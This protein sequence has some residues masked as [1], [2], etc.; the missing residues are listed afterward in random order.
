MVTRVL[1]IVATVLLLASLSAPVQASPGSAGCGIGDVTAYGA[2]GDDTTDDTSAIQAAMA[3]AGGNPLCFPAGNYYFSDTLTHTPGYI[4]AGRQST[5]LH[6][7]GTAEAISS[8]TPGTT[9]YNTVVAG[10]RLADGGTGTVGLDL[11]CVSVANLSNILV[12]GFDAGIKISCAL[13]GG[14]LYDV[15]TDVTV[16]HSTLGFWITG[17]NS[18]E[19]K[20]YACRTNVVTHAVLIDGGGRNVFH[21]C[22]FENGED[23]VELR[24]NVRRNQVMNSR[25]EFIPGF[26]VKANAG[27]QGTVLAWNDLVGASAG[28]ITHG[29]DTTVLD[30]QPG[31]AALNL[32][33]Q[34]ISGS[35]LTLQ[36]EVS[37]WNGTPLLVQRTTDDTQLLRLNGDG[38]LQLRVVTSLP[39]ASMAGTGALLVYDSPSAPPRLVLSLGTNWVYVDSGLPV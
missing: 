38:A 17:V 18:N 39:S 3:A 2:T 24:N 21:G 25:F 20:F 10:L 37:R 30:N 8:P 36:L 15:F 27:T 31:G 9:T 19:H 4:G 6:Y 29:S 11:A 12:Q 13:D 28:Y 34:H 5:H 16:S 32:S 33:D 23:G 1:A 35:A 26:A 22:A 7:T 14:A